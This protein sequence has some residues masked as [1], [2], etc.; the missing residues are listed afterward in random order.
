ME[1]KTREDVYHFLKNNCTYIDGGSQGECYVDRERKLVYKLYFSFLDPIEGDSF[2]DKSEVLAFSDIE[3][4]LCIFP[5]DVIT[6]KKVVI[7]D[8]T[9]YVNAKNLYKINPL[10]INI[11][12][13]IKLCELA[14]KE[15]ELL[16]RK[17]IKMFDVLYNIML[18]DKLYIVDTLEYS[19]SQREYPNVLSFNLAQ[20]NLSIMYFLIS[21]IFE[22]V[23][24]YNYILQGMYKS[25]G[26]DISII[27]FIKELKRYL[28]ELV[29]REIT[30]LGE[31]SEFKN[32]K[33]VDTIY[34]RLLE[35]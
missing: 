24:K 10:L 9:D 3:S 28:S 17:N 35:L 4:D 30:I 19:R 33:P 5:K 20:F 7:G 29:G 26:H 18:G 31:A 2:L 13:L 23:I 22:E 16:A 15:V 32:K 21:G 25:L 12:R 27:D 8:I 34:V 11:N 1:F 6:L 14:L